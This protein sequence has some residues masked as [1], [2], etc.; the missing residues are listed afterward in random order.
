MDFNLLRNDKF[1]PCRVK[2]S[3][4]KTVEDS[5]QMISMQAKHRN[6]AVVIDSFKVVFDALLFD[7]MRFQQVIVNLLTNAIK[8]SRAGGKVLI[9]LKSVSSK[10]DPKFV[11]LVVKVVD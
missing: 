6:V 10:R 7:K 8:F 4:L 5:V 1:K 2:A 3:V 11:N 9:K